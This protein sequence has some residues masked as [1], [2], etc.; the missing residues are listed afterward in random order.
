MEENNIY[1]KSL[2]K[3]RMGAGVIIKNIAGKILML[4]LTYKNSM[5]IPGGVVENDESP[6]EACQRELKEELG[7]ELDIKKMLCVDYN[8]QEG[9]YSESLMFIFDG[10]IISNQQIQNLKIQKDEIS[11]YEFLTLKEI[12]YR[13][14]NRLFKRIKKCIDAIEDNKT[15]Y[16][17]NQQNI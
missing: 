3:K 8:S 7:I 13:T 17:E 14:S 9:S 12:K 2:P 10:G 15:Y 1:L 6:L 4:N 16:L 11:S 5:E